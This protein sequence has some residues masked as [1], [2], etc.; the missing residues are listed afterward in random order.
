MLDSST[1]TRFAYMQHVHW[2]QN[3]LRGAKLHARQ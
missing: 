2:R 3:A 1:V